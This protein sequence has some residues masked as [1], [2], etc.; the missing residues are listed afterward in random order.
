MLTGIDDREVIRAERRLRE[1][2]IAID[3]AVLELK[4]RSRRTLT[5]PAILAL[6]LIAGGIAGIGSRRATGRSRQEPSKV[7]G[8]MRSLWSPLLQSLAAA[9][10]QRILRQ[11]DCDAVPEGRHRN[12]DRP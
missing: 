4:R 9:A 8:V 10:V 12:H 11:H 3:H 5:S 1:D 7:G 2:R 6:L